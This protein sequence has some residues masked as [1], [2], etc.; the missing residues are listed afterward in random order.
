[1]LLA[2]PSRGQTGVVIEGIVTNSVTHAAVSGAFV[3]LSTKREQYEV[4]TDQ[5]GAYRIEG[6]KSGRYTARFS[7]TG[8]LESLMGD[9][10]QEAQ[11]PVGT[12]ALRLDGPLTPLATIRGRVLDPEGKPAAGATVGSQHFVS[13]VTDEAGQFVL[14]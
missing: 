13:A 8:F 12:A 6:L 9:G 2:S 4:T 3:L 10:I 11:I 5:T 1:M 14:D 7:K